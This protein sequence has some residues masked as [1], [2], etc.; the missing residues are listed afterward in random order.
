MTNPI[1]DPLVGRTVAQYEILARVGG[2][3][4]GVVYRARDLKLGRI[5]ALK[6]LPQQWSHDDTAKQR[7]VR[8]A[9]AAS[10]TNHPNICTIH[11][12]ETA[13]DGQLFI[14]MAYYEGPTLK[15]RLE[16]GA[17]PIEEALDIATQIAD[18]LAKAHGQGVVHRDIKPGNLILTEDGV[19][20]LDFGLATFADALKL[21]TENATLGTAAYMSPE[22]VRG[23]PS[24]ARSDVWAVGVVLYE[25]LTGRVPFQGS[26]AEAIGYAVRNEAPTPLRT[27]RP[28]ASEEVEQ[29]VFRA[30]HKEPSVRY[31]SGRELARA[32]RQV[33]GYSVPLDLRT[34]PVPAPQ[35]IQSLALL[36]P[37]RV[38]AA[39]SL[40]L[41][42][43]MS[44]AY[45][46]LV[47]ADRVRVV[48]APFGNQTGDDD[49]GQYRLALT[50]TLAL[51]LRD[52]PDL[53][54][55][56]YGRVSDIAQKFLRAGADVSNREAIQAIAAQT[57]G[58]LVIVPNLLREGG[59]WR[60][61]VEL[62]NSATATSDWTY[63]TDPMTSSLSRDTAYRLAVALAEPVEE[64]LRSR[65]SHLVRLI[66]GVV[67]AGRREIAWHMRS[68]DAAKAFEEGTRWYEGL[69]YA[70][71]RRAFASAVE[72]DP[73]NPMALSW[74]SRTEQFTKRD[75]EAADAAER[76]RV[77]LTDDTPTVDALFVQ[78][79]A[80]EV[81][82]DFRAAEASYRELATWRSEEPLWTMEL[83][84]Y[85][86]RRGRT[87]D[88]VA[89]YHEA[90]RLDDGLLR[91]HLELCR[92]YSPSR[93]NEP[94]EAK[95]Q[96]QMALDRY[97]SL[98]ARGGEGQSLLCLADTLRVGSDDDRI[99]A[100][101]HAEAARDAFAEIDFSYNVARAEYYEALVAGMQGRSAESV[102]LGESA[103]A[104]AKGA[105]NV[106]LQPLIL[107]NLGSAHLGR[108][109]PMRAADDYRRAYE[110]YQQ[111]REEPR[112]AQIQANRGSMLI[113]SGNPVEGILDVRNA[114]AVFQKYTDRDYEVFC[115]R[116]IATYYRNQGRYQ[117]AENELRKARAIAS[118]WNLTDKVT[119][120]ATHIALVRFDLGDYG[121]A[122]QLQADALKGG[123]A[124]RDTE[125]RIR[126]ARTRTRLGDFAAADADL[127]RAEME[128]ELSPNTV[129]R[130]LLSMV[131]GEWAY[132]S[133]RPAE[134][135]SHMQRASEPW[136]AT[137]PEVTAVEAHAYVGMVRALEGDGDGGRS[138]VR[139]SLEAAEKLG[140]LALQTRCRLLMVE[141]DVVQSRFD[142]ADEA[143]KAI[144]PD[145]DGRS[146]GPELRAEV[147]YWRSR[148]QAGRGDA[149]SARSEAAAAKALIDTIRRGLPESYR[150]SFGA[151]PSVGRLTQ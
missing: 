134:A 53:S 133:L 71:A 64:H 70:A 106:A 73:R 88:A 76:A 62:R 67:G 41:L 80:S 57:S 148:I 75:N 39:A 120:V 74:L 29:L 138:M 33:R 140:Q 123:T 102:T 135:R 36:P 146:I 99:Q 96:G 38:V 10:A 104:R 12:I 109:D 6:F 25:M 81:R 139:A 107:L 130:P 45:L 13:D 48:V 24:D 149:A 11:D 137:Q 40:F 141:I 89:S 118:Q 94:A 16:D 117:D 143:L 105:G 114:L 97:R 22:Q 128:L 14:V 98:G 54:V 108:G 15:Q 136:A 100:R 37:K 115:L 72:Q 49:L 51:A 82:R 4:M 86:D 131:R 66:L 116:V 93:L 56:P 58:A 145:T 27:S 119:Q 18:G 50:Q 1:N 85:L 125:T 34:E 7:F 23:Q 79:V 63:E 3:G 127:T 90:L 69:E 44:W 84:G 28:E 31:A 121:T 124:V 144:P 60:A 78:A 129:L 35:P 17:L 59:E 77:L 92:L 91:P 113:D 47:P 55:V 21:T 19:R 132:E 150:E 32:L 68:L 83:G 87:A 42:A 9:Q 110:L 65:R 122:L 5:V 2:G 101:A 103:L 30:L 52:S 126:L 26:H 112:A 142:Q 61:R 147:H 95:K 8:E 151:R 46:W 20:I 43:G 111:W